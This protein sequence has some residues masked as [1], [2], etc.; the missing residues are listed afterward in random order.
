MKRNLPV[1]AVT[2]LLVACGTHPAGPSSGAAGS[3]LPLVLK[4]TDLES[5]PGTGGQNGRGA[6]VT[7][8]GAGFGGGRGESY[9]TV[10]G[11]RVEDYPAWSATRIVIQLGPNARTGDLQVHVGGEASNGLPFT[12]RPG[13]LYFVSPSGDDSAAGSF[14]SPWRS[15]L[16]AKNALTP[17]DIAY[18]M[19]GVNQAGLDE[20]A[21]SVSITSSGAPG[22][23]KALVAYPGAQATIGNVQIGATSLGIRVPNLG[24][25]ATDWVIA[26]LRL[27][28]G[29]TALDIGGMGSGSHR[30]RVVGNHIS[31]PNGDGQTG[32]VSVYQAN[33][34]RFLGNEVTDTGVAPATSKQYHAVYFTTDANDVEVGWNWIHDNRTCHAVQFHSSPIG[35]GTGFNQYNLSVHDNRIHGDRCAGINFATVDPARGKVE[36]YNNLIYDV[37]NGPE[38]PDGLSGASCVYVPGYTNAGPD[39]TGN[40]EVYNNTCVEVGR[41]GGGGPGGAFLRFTDSPRLF[42]NLRNNV[43]YQ[44]RSPYLAGWSA[45][46]LVRGEN[47]L[48]F[49]QGPGPVGMVGNV[50]SDPM[51]VDAGSRDYHLRPGSPAI[52]AGAATG[53][54]R[55]LDGRARQPPPDM[56][57]YEAGPTP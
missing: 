13:G 32:C 20:Y 39:G 24:I 28:G 47:N 50:S 38:P 26:G 34:T 40:V 41:A 42:L 23:P 36:A 21:A 7:L 22:R 37:G 27:R 11:G 31:C 49:G 18:L 51:F 12:V 29:E 15:V 9:V 57:A 46:A 2:V 54:T 55:D 17:G 5:G 1:G 44:T 6:F 52:N 19:D 35:P 48:W 25:A 14:A 8:Y 33:Q 10:G 56:G 3:S 16:R 4:Y 43:V 30:W 45:P 53:V